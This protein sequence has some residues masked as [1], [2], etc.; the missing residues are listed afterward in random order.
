MEFHSSGIVKGFGGK[1]EEELL[2][3]KSDHMLVCHPVG[4]A[5]RLPDR[6]HFSYLHFALSL[7]FHLSTFNILLL[8]PYEQLSHVI[9]F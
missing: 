7:R 6:P 9:S 5:P 3:P 1:T 8:S 4:Q 2:F